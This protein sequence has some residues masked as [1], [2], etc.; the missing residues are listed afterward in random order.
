MVEQRQKKRDKTLM[1]LKPERV[2]LYKAYMAKNFARA[3]L[4]LEIQR[5]P[6]QTNNLFFA[7]YDPQ[8]Y[9]IAEYSVSLKQATN[10]LIKCQHDF[11]ELV[12][13][14]FCVKDGR[15]CQRTVSQALKMAEFNSLV[16]AKK[17]QLCSG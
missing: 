1:P 2:V 12:K 15:I 11:S 5:D 6:A 3:P 9:R 7:T 4:L 8:G 13:A 10:L 16:T 17:G 14:L